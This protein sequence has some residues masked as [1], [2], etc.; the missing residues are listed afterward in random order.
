VASASKKRTQKK[1]K[2]KSGKKIL[3]EAQWVWGRVGNS[4]K[5][6]GDHKKGKSGWG[7]E[8]RRELTFHL[9]NARKEQGGWD[10]K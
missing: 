6:K 5:L 10:N 2:T 3:P 9:R 7:R 4:Q 8:S 1:K